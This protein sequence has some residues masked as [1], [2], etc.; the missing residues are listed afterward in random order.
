MERDP[1]HLAWHAAPAALG[2]S[3]DRR[4]VLARLP[5][6]RQRRRRHLRAALLQGPQRYTNQ[7][8]VDPNQPHPYRD[9]PAP[10]VFGN[11]PPLDPQLFSR[12]N[13]FADELLK[14]ERSG[15]YSPIEVAQW[16]EDYAAAAAKHLAGIGKG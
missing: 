4:G 14:G 3:A 5:V 1:P 9:S 13:D 2:R 12:I 16:I 8:I 11:A 7:S 10:R 6:L 15:R